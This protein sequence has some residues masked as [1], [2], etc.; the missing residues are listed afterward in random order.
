MQIAIDV[1]GF[2]P[3]QADRLRKAMSA[4]RSRR[5]MQALKAELMDGMAARGVDEATGEE[6]YAKLRAF[7]EFGF[8][9]SHAFSFA[10]LVYASAWLKV[11]IPSTSTRGSSP[12]SRWASTL[13]SPW[14]PTPS[15][16]G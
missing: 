9:E 5:R 11:H 8:P 13:T 16:T 12:R 6:I 15:A 1:A 10:Y 7:A 4:K 14:W 2:S 3:A